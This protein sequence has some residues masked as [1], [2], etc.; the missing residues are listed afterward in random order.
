MDRLTFI[1]YTHAHTCGAYNPVLP[2]SLRFSQ[3]VGQPL[4][5][6]SCLLCCLCIY[7][8]PQLN[9]LNPKSLPPPPLV[10]QPYSYPLPT[11]AG[12][13]SM[14]ST[15]DTKQRETDTETDKH[16]DGQAEEN[17]GLNVSLTFSFLLLSS[18]RSLCLFLLGL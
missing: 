4:N 8:S 16:T 7:F 2:W 15:R 5:L 11:K 6:T 3:Q 14:A 18:D 1:L 9:S 13:Y 12:K 10:L 17:R